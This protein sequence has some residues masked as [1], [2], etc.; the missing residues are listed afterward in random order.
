MNKSCHFCTPIHTHTHTR[1]KSFY[2]ISVIPFM[3]IFHFVYFY[4]KNLFLSLSFRNVLYLAQRRL[5]SKE[6]ITEKFNFQ[7]KYS[8]NSG[9]FKLNFCNEQTFSMH[10]SAMKLLF[11]FFFK[12]HPFA[13]R[14]DIS[15]YSLNFSFP[16][17]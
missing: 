12:C 2:S 9:S 15:C 16:F 14:P 3:C 17:M 13:S 11:G 4:F 8:G 1:N 6:R 5:L 7:I 10:F